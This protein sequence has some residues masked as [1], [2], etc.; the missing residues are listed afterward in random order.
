[1]KNAAFPWRA[2]PVTLA[3][4]LLLAACADSDPQK[5][6]DSARQYLEKKDNAAAIIQLKNALQESPDLAEAR[7]LLG[8]TLLANGDA[9][10]A[11]TELRK[12]RDLGQ[13]ADQV[14]PLLAR[15][16]LMQGQFRKVTSEFARMQLSSA[17]ATA[18]LKTLVAVAWRQQ[19][20][21]SAFQSSLQ[22]ALKAQPDHAPA[23]IEEA[24]FKAGQRDFDGALK[25]LD[26]VLA[27]T[28]K[29]ADALKLRGDVL[30]YG[31]QQP[32][33][34]LAAYRAAVE[35]R[36]NAQD[37]Q[38]GVIQVLLLQNRLDE[39][40]K[41]VANLAKFAN[42]RPQ[43]R[44][45]QARLAFQK[46]DLAAAKEHIQQLLKMTPDS[47]T[48]LEMAGVIEAETGSAVQAQSYL[49]RALQA[50]PHLRIARRALVVSYLRTGQADRAVAALPPGLATDD[51]DP[52][53][54][55]LAGQ[56]YMV[57]GDIDQAQRYLERA[58][59][60]D[61][62]DPRNQTTLALSH[63]ASGQTEMAL[64]QLQNVASTDTGVVADMA[65]INTHM[66]ARNAGKALEAIDALDKKLPN[67]PMV[68]QLRGR[69]LLM[70]D[71]RAGAR[72]AFERAH[73]IDANY[74]AAT[75]ALAA[76]DIVERKP[77][78]AQKRLEAAVQRQPSNAQ[79]LMAL[80]EVRGG[81]G[82]SKEE[83][84]DIIRRAVDAAPTERAPRLMLVEHYLRHN[85]AKTALTVAQSAA[86]ALPDVPDLVDA[87]G[88]A[89]TAS[90][91]YNQALT[92][93]NKLVGLMP[94]SP[95]PYLRLAMLST[96]QKDVPGTEQNLRKALEIQPD[97]LQAQRGLAELAVAGNRRA[98]AVAISRTVQKQRPTE[99]VGYLMEGDLQLAAKNW[100][101]SEE[102]YR[103]GLKAAPGPELAV[104]LHTALVS[105]GKAAEADRVS[106]DWLRE[107]PNEPTMLQYLGDRAISANRLSDAVR[108]YESLLAVQPNNALALNNL[109][110]AA[111]RLGR[112]DAVALA[113]KANQVA[114]NQPAFMDTLAALLSERNEH[115]RA[116]TLQKRVLELRPNVPLFKLN[117]AKIHLK[118]G[119]KNAAKPLLDE[120]SALGDAFPAQAEVTQ[121]KQGL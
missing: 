95:L 101:A 87:L 74:F 60:L 13:P 109:A 107:H 32:E 93:F 78:E 105:G 81:A 111:G 11:E 49:T 104:K 116:L 85:D 98:D 28:P 56:A 5:M 82:G 68:S 2:A 14:A 12:A 102:A 45:L 48:A 33:P 24:R 121:L 29:D 25:V 84:A 10:G 65:L 77:Q 83:V 54:L 34:A 97:Q 43:T 51:S 119:D 100:K 115:A 103:A 89:Q 17:Q 52:A 23:L 59:R 99:A 9:V 40:E 58:A 44:Y 80:A 57:R 86:A 53:M 88:R 71:D 27:R 91:E 61:P 94:N 39:A 21:Q 47:P 62:K 6:L 20:D 92:N 113:E 4:A 16:Q 36:P 42:G 120:L 110:W 46:N 67:D 3:V 106:A 66:R 19:G 41:E 7:F 70:R 69:A 22:E 30:L 96:V 15:S 112:S 26:E 72:K 31:K 55:S 76:L 79:A 114:P 50:A 35:A 108:H 90:G 73:E 38:G 1:M 75:A 117:M 8:K 37:A 63:L 18:E 118:A 64:Q